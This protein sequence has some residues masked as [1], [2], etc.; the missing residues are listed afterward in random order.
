MKKPTF[1]LLVPLIGILSFCLFANLECNEESKQDDPTPEEPDK[2]GPIVNLDRTFELSPATHYNGV[3]SGW[4][5]FTYS[6]PSVDDVCAHKHI[7]LW[8][9]IV[10]KKSYGTDIL[11][12]AE[13]MYGIFYTYPVKNWSTS[14]GSGS[15]AIAYA[16]VEFGMLSPYGDDPG[17]FYPFMTVKIRSQGDE[18]ANYA[19][20]LEV[21]EKVCITYQY[22]KWKDNSGG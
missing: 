15:S 22:Y 12:E 21:V 16:P 8:F 13:V 9:E 1:S 10:Y 6:L 7:K 19:F 18:Y 20:F 5:I 17:Y 14:G 4:A 3:E 2:C 11:Y